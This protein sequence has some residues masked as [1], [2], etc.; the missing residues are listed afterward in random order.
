MQPVGCTGSLPSLGSHAYLADMTYEEACRIVERCG[1]TAACQEWLDRMP[2]LTP[3]QREYLAM[4]F[5][6]RSAPGGAVNRS[7]APIASGHDLHGS[8]IEPS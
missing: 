2:P 3:A 5:R 4:I 6:H 7:A 8:A 1:T